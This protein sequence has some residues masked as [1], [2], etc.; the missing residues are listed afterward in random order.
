MNRWSGM[1]AI[2]AIVLAAC[3]T[4]A[5]GSSDAPDEQSLP[6]VPP[7]TEVPEATEPA[8][9]PGD[10]PIPVEPNNGI[11]D[12]ATGE[13]LPVSLDGPYPLAVSDLVERLGVAVEDISIVESRA[14]TWGDSSLGC[15]EPGKLY[16][17]VLTSGWLTVLEADGKTY[18]YHA[19][20][21]DPFLCTNPVAPSDG[22][23]SD[24]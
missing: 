13:D 3:G 23:S 8:N 19:G 21:G 6:T 5:G 24:Y 17:Q 11:G 15:P 4:P 12:G 14:V 16:T 9:E 22:E 10:T 1:L 2:G 18:H 20:S 7:G